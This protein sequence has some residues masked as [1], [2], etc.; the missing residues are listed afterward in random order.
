MPEAEGV[1][2]ETVE[3][4]A[5]VLANND[6]EMASIPLAILIA[7]HLT[8]LEADEAPLD[9]R[10]FWML[11]I[12]ES[13]GGT[14]DASDDG[15]W[16]SAFCDDLESDVSDTFNRAAEAGY[17]SVTHDNDMGTSTARLTDAGRAALV[18][19]KAPTTVTAHKSQGVPFDASL[20]RALDELEAANEGLAAVRSDATY[21][22]M[23]DNDQATDQL[24]RLEEARRIARALL[25]G[26]RM[27]ERYITCWRKTGD[28]VL[29]WDHH[30]SEDAEEAARC[31]ANLLKQDVIQYA[32][33][34]LGAPVP[35]LTVD[36]SRKA[37][38]E[39]AE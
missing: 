31:V 6:R 17:I 13:M 34:H 36:F 1:P 12:I 21:L 38:A 10:T 26:K 5:Y 19:Q 29:E 14:S 24:N 25:E 28:K 33:Y 35:E 9:E 11:S 30:V 37:Q 4:I 22:S 8:S 39:A 7:E 20:I 15:G 23:V 3:A 16:L 18:A 32:T 2:I 27:G